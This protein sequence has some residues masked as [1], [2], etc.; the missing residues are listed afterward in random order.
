[1][2]YF[3]NKILKSYIK[4]KTPLYSRLRLYCSFKRS[5]KRAGTSYRLYEL[6]AFSVHFS[7][8]KNNKDDVV[9]AAGLDYCQRQ[10]LLRFQHF[11]VQENTFTSF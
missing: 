4:K 11:I 7:K 5:H 2:G 1:M 8:S 10:P 3:I 6:K 9:A